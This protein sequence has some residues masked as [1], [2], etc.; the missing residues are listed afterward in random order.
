[1]MVAPLVVGYGLIL[2]LMPD[3][4]YRFGGL[5]ALAIVAGGLSALVRRDHN[6]LRIARLWMQGKGQSLSNHVWNGATVEPFPRR[7]SKTARG[8]A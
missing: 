3:W 2:A 1:M 5:F 8:I 6:A 4:H 7:R